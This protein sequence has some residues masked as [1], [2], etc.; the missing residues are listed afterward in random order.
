MTIRAYDSSYLQGA[1]NILGNAVD[2][3]VMTLGLEPDTFGNAFRVSR[4]SNQFA[5]GNP[6]YVAGMNGCELARAVLT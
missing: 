1:Q 5:S 6:K 2:W 4:I 3:S